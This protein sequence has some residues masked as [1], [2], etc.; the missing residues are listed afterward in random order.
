MHRECRERFPRHRLQRKPQVSDPGMHHSTCVTH[1]PW[2]MLGSLTRGGREKVP[3][4]PGE[5]ATRNFMYLIRGPSPEPLMTQFVPHT[6]VSGLKCVKIHTVQSHYNAV[7]FL[8]YPCNRHP[9]VSVV[10]LKCDLRPHCH[11][12]VLCNIVKKG[13]RYNGTRLYLGQQTHC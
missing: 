2:C 6:L 9:R 7:N 12:S 11:G 13:P 3:G 5:C 1:V 8:Q 4:I 10:S